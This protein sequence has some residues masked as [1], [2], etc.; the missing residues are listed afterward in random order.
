MPPLLTP[1]G[2]LGKFGRSSGNM[3]RDEGHTMK[4]LHGHEPAIEWYDPP[5]RSY[6]SLRRS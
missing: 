2:K 1:K 3:D 4:H 6:N 5:S